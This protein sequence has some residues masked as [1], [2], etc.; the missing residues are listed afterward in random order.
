MEALAV[1]RQTIYHMS[2]SCPVVSMRVIMPEADTSRA[3]S[4]RNCFPANQIERFMLF[5]NAWSGVWRL[6]P[7]LTQAA[8]MHLCTLAVVNGRLPSLLARLINSS[9]ASTDSRPS[10]SVASINNLAPC[11]RFQ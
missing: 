1:I 4:E 6:V 2:G 5:D 10:I 3:D 8:Y 9:V 11:L 7:L